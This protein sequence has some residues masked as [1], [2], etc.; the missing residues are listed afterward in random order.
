[1]ARKGSDSPYVLCCWGQENLPARRGAEL[2][3]D[4]RQGGTSGVNCRES[5]AL[6]RH[7]CSSCT[8]IN[9]AL[10]AHVRE[11]SSSRIPEV[12]MRSYKARPK[13]QACM[14]SRQARPNS[15][16]QAQSQAPPSWLQLSPPPPLTPHLVPRRVS[17]ARGLLGASQ[18][19]MPGAGL[20]G[21]VRQPTLWLPFPQGDSRVFCW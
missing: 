15:T 11:E 20:E 18:L 21:W 14:R 7:N 17:A 3:I 2:D 16:A 1:M 19:L 8:V 5:A 6:P 10:S 13:G 9:A 4:P 12:H